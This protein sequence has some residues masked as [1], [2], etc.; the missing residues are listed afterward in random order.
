MTMTD[1]MLAR[2][3]AAENEIEL[4]RADS[5]RLRSTL[6]AT[7]QRLVKAMLEIGEVYNAL[8]ALGIDKWPVQLRM[9]ESERAWER[10]LLE[11]QG[12]DVRRGG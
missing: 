1:D 6:R 3:R 8:D 5:D 4:L 9:M 12:R 7:E 11:E 10:Y 2:L